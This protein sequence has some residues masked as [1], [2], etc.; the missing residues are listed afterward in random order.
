MRA[1]IVRGDA[2]RFVEACLEV[3]IHWWGRMSRQLESLEYEWLCAAAD[4]HGVVIEPDNDRFK[5]YKQL[6]FLLDIHYSRV[7]Q[8]ERRA[9]EKMREAIEDDDLLQEALAEIQAENRYIRAKQEHGSYYF[10]EEV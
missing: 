10:E 7:Q 4:K 1:V 8:I 6:A 5:T 2:G 9:L 3:G